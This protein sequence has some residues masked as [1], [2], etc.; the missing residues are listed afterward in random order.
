MKKL[1]GWAG[2]A[3]AAALGLVPSLALGQQPLE[4][5]LQAASEGSLDVAVAELSARE[6]TAR[7]ASARSA[8]LPRLSADAGYTRN[9]IEIAV[10]F[11]GADGSP[12]EAVISAQDQLDATLRADWTFFDVASMAQIR[13]VEASTKAARF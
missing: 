7:R 12:E 1:P 5:F 2:G 3:L 13:S 6:A 11:P 4:D 10:S 8:L 9:Q